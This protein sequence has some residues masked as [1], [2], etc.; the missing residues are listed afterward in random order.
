MVNLRN[1]KEEF[2]SIN[3]IIYF[4]SNYYFREKTSNLSKLKQFI[5]KAETLLEQLKVNETANKDVV[6]FLYGILGNLYRIYG[7]PQTAICYLNLCLKYSIEDGDYTGEIISLIRLGEAYKYDN[8]HEKALEKFNQAINK[9][10]KYKLDSYL[11]FVL[12]HKG[13]CLLELKKVE[14]AIHCLEK[15][16][17]IRK[18][19]GDISLIQSTK[20]ALE[21]GDRMRDE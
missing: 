1:I 8:K 12:Q 10:K 15:A 18:L 7:E 16:L 2:A 14:E 6:D 17:E 11:D 9:C 19:K 13:K 20:Q 3:E 21:M 4:D 5:I